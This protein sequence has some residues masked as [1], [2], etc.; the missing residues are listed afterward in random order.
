MKTMRMA[1]L[2][3]ALTLVACSSTEGGNVPADVQPDSGVSIKPGDTRTTPKD[4]G[5]GKVEDV[6]RAGEEVNLPPG[7]LD[8]C[9]SDADCEAWGLACFADG[10]ADQEAVCSLECSANGDCPEMMVCKNKGETK[11]CRTAGYCD[12][13]EDDEQCGDNGRCIEDKTGASFCSYPCVKDDPESCGAGNF[14]NKVGQGL[15]DYYCFPMFGACKGDGTHCTPCQN[16][17]DCLKGHECHENAYTFERY[18]GKI[19]QVKTD[20]P[21]GFGCYEL[22]GEDYPLCTLEVE[23]NPVETCYK[24][25][26]GFCEPCMLN[27]ECESGVCYNYAVAN[28]YFCSFPCDPNEYPPEGCPSGLYCVPNHG[29]SGGE[30]CAP[31]LAFGCQGFLNCVAVECVKGEKCVEGFC[32]PK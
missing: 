32:E 31:A 3:A 29:E 28:K 14:C 10:P 5:S 30:I 9:L 6:P 18:C 13:C 12:L 4:T 20:C 23:N 8:F 7:Y 19:C 2:M 15:E 17:D 25:N 11:I 26:K 1:A 21:K 27:Y 16:D 22:T 24:G